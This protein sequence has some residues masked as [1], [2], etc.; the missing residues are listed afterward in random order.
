MRIG[1]LLI[2]LVMGIF[3]WQG[4]SD[5]ASTDTKEVVTRQ[6][7]P[8][9]ISY[10]K[11]EALS[12]L[13]RIRGAMSMQFLQENTSLKKAAQAHAD[14]LVENDEATH[15]EIK[16]NKG[17]L[18]ASAV[19][20]AFASGYNASR[21]L[22]NLSTK[23]EN[24]RSSVDGL[25]S[26]IYHRFSFLDLNIDEIGVGVQQDLKRTAR[27][28]FVYNMG[29]SDLNR[30]CSQK[31]FNGNGTYVYGVCKDKA[32]RINEKTFHTALNNAK[33]YSPNII[34]YPYDGQQ[35]VPPAFYDEIPDPLPHHEVSGF[36]VSIEFNDHFFDDVTVH[37]FKLYIE[38]GEEIHD[39]QLMDKHTDPNHLF[40]KQ[41]YAL[42]PLKRLEYDSEYRVEVLYAFNGKEKKLVWR[43][44]TKTLDEKLHI[45]TEREDTIQIKQSESHIVYFQPLDSHDMM[46]DIQLPSDVYIEFIDH[47][48]LKITL[49][50]DN[51]DSF[52]IISDTR[53][54][55]V[56]IE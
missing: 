51:M 13:N 7:L 10:E 26:A 24:A 29:N 22:E 44:K 15:D 45:V 9:D 11:S 53:I 5:R 27:S 20:R 12:Y 36:P 30:V 35:D 40:T 3:F 46:G 33:Q 41:Q 19:K 2:L 47:H 42:F 38:T 50:S 4:I 37:S 34:V 52:D 23:N 21:V 16:G 17:F 28:A 18:G 25:F 54:L 49:M 39:V 48:S 31:S 32:H 1:F 14:Y 43:F 6:A 55:H 56:D 8:M